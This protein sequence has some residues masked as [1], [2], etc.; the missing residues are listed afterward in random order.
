ML[1]EEAR[2]RRALPSV[3]RFGAPQ[4]VLLAPNGDA[5]VLASAKQ[6]A[7]VWD[8]WWSIAVA[9]GERLRESEASENT[10]VSRAW[11][12]VSVVT[13]KPGPVM[14][15]GDETLELWVQAEI[16]LVDDAAAAW[17]LS[18]A[19]GEDGPW[20]EVGEGLDRT[21]TGEVRWDLTA[22]ARALGGEPPSPLGSMEATYA[23]AVPA[24]GALRSVSAEVSPYPTA[25]FRF[26]LLGD[27]Q[28][29]FVGIVSVTEDGQ[30][31]PARVA[32]FH[33]E[34][35]GRAQGVVVPY[36]LSEDT[37][38]TVALEELSFRS[39]WSAQGNLLWQ[40]GDAGILE[41]GA[42]SDCP[43]PDPF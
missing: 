5:A 2:F 42:E 24:T 37:G 27:Q 43:V 1:Y 38:G 4:E 9:G 14:G 20:T 15:F 40:Q 39:C 7:A 30:S 8:A 18:V 3:E 22:T 33:G 34:Q 28:F 41:H 32:A 12:S 21:G 17:T 25:L 36:A 31:W 26:D 29:G 16:T 6:S 19:P 35:G 10:D 13:R 23:D 11:S